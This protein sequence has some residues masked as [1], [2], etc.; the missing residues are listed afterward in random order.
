MVAEDIR[1][2]Q[3]WTGHSAGGYARGFLFLL[4][5]HFLR[6]CD[7]RSSGLDGGDH[8]GGD[9]HVARGGIQFVV[10]QQRLDLSDIGSAIEQVGGKAVAQRMQRHASS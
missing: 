1:D 5:L 6:G 9:A 8:A 10:P 2:L 3:R 4:L 7:N